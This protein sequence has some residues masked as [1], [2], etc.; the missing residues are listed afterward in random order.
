MG[1]AA[2]TSRRDHRAVSRRGVNSRQTVQVREPRIIP[3]GETRQATFVRRC[4][5]PHLT[6][7]TTPHTRHTIKHSAS[8]D[9]RP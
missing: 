4:T 9:T 2:G 5:S 1:A 8:V 3:H 7:A 6:G